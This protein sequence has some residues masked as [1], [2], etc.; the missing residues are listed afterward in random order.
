MKKILVA[1]L[2]LILTPFLAANAE[3]D[4]LPVYIFTQTGCPYCA[5][6]LKHLEEVKESTYPELEVIDYDLRQNPGFVQ[7]FSQYQKAYSTYADGVPVTFIGNKVIKGYLPNEID[8][9]LAECKNNTNCV[10]PEEVVEKYLEENPDAQQE[11]SKEKTVMGWVVIGVVIVGG[12][13]L[14][15]SRK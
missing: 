10:N 8:V 3:E 12:A 11:A 6:T 9:A 14:L 2:F 1:L 15:L 4:T 7:K 5:Q 13:V